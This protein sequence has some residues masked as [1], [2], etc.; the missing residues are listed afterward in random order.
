ME[1]IM[2][3]INESIKYLVEYEKVLNIVHHT[4]DCLHDI[5]AKKYESV[6]KEFSDLYHK[7][8]SSECSD[9]DYKLFYDM[10]CKICNSLEGSKMIVKHVLLIRFEKELDE[11]RKHKDELIHADAVNRGIYEMYKKKYDKSDE[12][13][14]AAQK[15]YDESRDKFS[16][17]VDIE[18]KQL[19]KFDVNEWY[20]NDVAYGNFDFLRQKWRQI[21]AFLED[22]RF[23]LF[24]AI[25]MLK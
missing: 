3:V 23:K 22:S 1:A 15:L 8:K 7:W 4:D 5:E 16:S 21:I 12:K 2:N 25:D 20:E 11:L 13:L 24:K 18:D 19:I 6:Y 10:R 14:I 17:A 9:D